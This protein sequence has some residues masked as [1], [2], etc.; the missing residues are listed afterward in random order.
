MRALTAAAEILAA[1]AIVTVA[2]SWLIERAHPPRGRFI[3]VDGLRQHVVALGV[4]TAAPPIVLI[5]GAGCNLEDMRLA[6]GERLA[7]RHRVI[8]IDRAGL[9]WS[10]RRGR[11][12]SP[13]YQAA[14]LRGVLDRLG[15]DRAIVVGHSWGG[16]LA[17]AFAL[18]SPRRV[19]G[20]VLLAPPLYPFPRR[21][22]WLYELFATPVAG[23]LYA[24]ALALPFGV[25]FIGLGLG[26]AFLP[27]LPPRG[28]IKRTAA[29]L[30]LRPATFLA[31][32]RDVADLG[33]NLVTQTARYPALKVP[34]IIMTGDRDKIVPLRSH[35]LAFAAAVPAT[36]LVVLPGVGH[37]LHHVATERVVA[38][39]EDVRRIVG[40][41]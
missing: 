10:A 16:A 27:Q 34:T 28:Y 8:L 5:H 11:D 15:V 4:E 6:L 9:G 38:E 37:M 22:T 2:G 33:A 18:D 17:A 19:A 40:G 21:M 20:L 24:R 7:A 30:L 31:N 14:I 41:Q 3:D 13:S 32:A 26:S 29:L 1:G 25:P 23:W 12:S 35:A 36:K 39:I